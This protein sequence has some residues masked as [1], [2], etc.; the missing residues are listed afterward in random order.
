M[1]SFI[2]LVP[3]ATTLIFCRKCLLHKLIQNIDLSVAT[4]PRIGIDVPKPNQGP[5]LL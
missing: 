3:R 5:I 4:F 1:A 2:V